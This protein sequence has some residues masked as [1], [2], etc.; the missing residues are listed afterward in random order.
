MQ[1]SNWFEQNSADYARFRP[2]YPSALIEFLASISPNQQLALDVGCGTG[3]LSQP[4]AKYFSHVIAVDPSASQLQHALTQPNLQYLCAPAEQ[5]PVANHCASL[6]TAAQAAHWFDLT[7]FYAEVQRVAQPNAILAL[8]SYGVVQ[9]EAPLNE[10]FKQFYYQ[11]IGHFWPPERALVDAGYQS[12]AFPFKPLSHPNFS[13]ELQWDFSAFLGYISTWS[14]IS[15]A[16][17]QG[18][19]AK[20]QQFADDL[21]LLWGEPQQQRKIYWPINL[22]LAKL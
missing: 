15:N 4:L 3:Q 16:K 7:M 22:R 8:I 13:I 9:L 2:N 18:A 21:L 20:L 12:L 5:L 19:L 1:I 10:R 14:A 6:I 11:E 17:Q